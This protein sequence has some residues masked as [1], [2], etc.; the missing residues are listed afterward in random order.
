MEEGMVSQHRTNVDTVDTVTIQSNGDRELNQSRP[1]LHAYRRQ[2]KDLIAT[3]EPLYLFTE[4]AG[5]E[6][7]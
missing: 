2:R 4:D 3:R 1:A 7:K 6:T 5:D